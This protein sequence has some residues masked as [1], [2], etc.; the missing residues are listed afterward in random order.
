MR[1]AGRGALGAGQTAGMRGGP[2]VSLAGN[3][4]FLS[5]T[6]ANF[7]MTLCITCFDRPRAVERIAL[8]TEN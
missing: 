5:F 3:E 7:H 4:G 2:I 8:S 6:G 1:R